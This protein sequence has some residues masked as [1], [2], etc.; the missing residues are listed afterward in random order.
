MDIVF[1]KLSLTIFFFAFL[2]ALFIASDV[3]PAFPIQSPTAPFLSPATSA[4][5]KENLRPPATTRVTRRIFKI[6]WSNSG[7]GLEKDEDRLLLFFLSFPFSI[8]LYS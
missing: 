1:V 5:L 3:S 8:F 2:N 4:T 6:F 7:L